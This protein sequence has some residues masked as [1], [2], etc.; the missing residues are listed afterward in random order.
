MVIALSN[1]LSVILYSNR[2]NI[3][4][5]TI[6]KIPCFHS[7]KKGRFIRQGIRESHSYSNQAAVPIDGSHLIIIKNYYTNFNILFTFHDF[8]RLLKMQ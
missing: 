3:V 7:N 6:K 5:T 2:S 1:V 8:P 4:D